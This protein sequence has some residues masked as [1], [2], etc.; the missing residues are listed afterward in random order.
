VAIGGW[1]S[2]SYGAMAGG[3]QDVVGRRY[4]S[5]ARHDSPVDERPRRR[6]ISS[7]YQLSVALVRLVEDLR[8][9]MTPGS[10]FFNLLAAFPAFEV[11]LLRL[12]T[13]EGMAIARPNGVSVATVRDCY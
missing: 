8:P 6:S 10:M 2:T 5:G 4:F 13:R 3:S 12:R 1:G 9:R 7:F 11:D